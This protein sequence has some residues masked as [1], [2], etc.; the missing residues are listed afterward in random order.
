VE[1]RLTIGKLLK[2]LL[3]TNQMSMRQLARLSDID[4]ATISR[5]VNGKRRPTLDHLRKFAAV[6]DISL[7]VLVDAASEETIK[8]K[9]KAFKPAFEKDVETLLPLLA[10][11]GFSSEHI[12]VKFTECM[13]A[14]EMEKGRNEVLRD[15]QPKLAHIQG[16]GPFIERL[17]A[18]YK[19][20]MQR[21]GTKRE[22]ILM[23]SALLYFILPIDA[24]PDHLFP[25]GYLDDAVV[26][27]MATN[28]LTKEKKVAR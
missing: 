14:V 22:M 6:F 21:E 27:Q 18:F 17:Q 20:F 13:Q 28:L 10:S 1:E 26:V 7:S 23:G 9:S 12:E 15:F 11:A 19:R 24:V 4:A 8:E 16:Q 5:I 2:Q 3:S 25:I